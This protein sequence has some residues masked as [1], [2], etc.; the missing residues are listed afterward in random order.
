MSKIIGL[1][2]SIGSGKSTTAKIL[3]ECY[4]FKELSFSSCLKDILAVMFDWDRELLEG[5]TIE[6]RKWRESTDEFWSKE[7]NRDITPRYIM[8]WF[9]TDIIRTQLF[10]DFW[11]VRIKK[12]IEQ[13]PDINYVISDVRF[14]NESKL[15]K[16]LNGKLI[17]I[18]RNE[19]PEWRESLSEENID[20][21]SKSHNIHK[22]EIEWM[23]A[24]IDYKLNN[25]SDLSKLKQ[26][27]AE[28]IGHI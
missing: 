11:I 1:C 7:L 6:S 3:T 4:N 26:E 14:L 18:V 23:L 15:I 20:E 24:D 17:E 19:D 13:N 21:I 27:I 2:G 10:S 28:L 25:T 8:Q 9:A 12:I 16:D 22:S 5:D